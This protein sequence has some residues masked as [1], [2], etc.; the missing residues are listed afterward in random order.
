MEAGRK[1]ER[2][3]LDRT[4]THLKRVETN[5]RGERLCP[6]DANPSNSIH[7][8]GFGILI[9]SPHKWQRV[10]GTFNLL[11]VTMELEWSRLGLQKYAYIQH[12]ALSKR[13]LRVAPEE[14][15]ILLKGTSLLKANRE[16]MTRIMFETFNSTAMCRWCWPYCPH[17]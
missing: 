2:S 9:R 1:E 7:S 8:Q 11:F 5:G 3:L 6:R 12:E 14:H 17:L 10:R 16:K 4:L 15:P 13:E